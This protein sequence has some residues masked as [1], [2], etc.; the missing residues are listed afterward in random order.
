MATSRTWGK[1]NLTLEKV[2]EPFRT[3]QEEEVFFTT[4][5]EGGRN[6]NL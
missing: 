2:P 4:E 5:E 1:A 6:R 3:E